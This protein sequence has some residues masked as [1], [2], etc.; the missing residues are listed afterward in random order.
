MII[1]A[2]KSFLYLY[3]ILI[4]FSSKTNLASKQN[5]DKLK[6]Q[7]EMQ[8]AETIQ[9]K[10][11]ANKYVQLTKAEQNTVEQMSKK[12]E[13]AEKAL[14]SYKVKLA[15]TERMKDRA[16]A[17]K[18]NMLDLAH[19]TFINNNKFTKMIEQTKEYANKKE[20][21]AIQQL[22]RA[23]EIKS[24]AIKKQL[25][26]EKYYGAIEQIIKNKENEFNEKENLLKE[27][28][29]ITKINLENII[30]NEQNKI[31]QLNKNYKLANQKIKD[32]KLK[33]EILTAKNESYKVKLS[34]E[35][36]QALELKKEIDYFETQ[37]TQTLGEFNPEP[38]I[39]RMDY[40]VDGVVPHLVKT[41][42]LVCKWLNRSLLDNKEYKIGKDL[43]V[44]DL[45]DKLNQSI[46]L[47]DR[48][49]KNL[50]KN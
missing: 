39:T 46:K 14:E 1:K 36:G 18:R 49:I 24:N 37:L 28:F 22:T 6:D 16:T 34:Q 12:A 11:M 29:K 26:A 21:F 7:L 32:L 8:K 40:Y 42:R 33:K 25:A 35:S 5:K 41:I 27:N 19:H 10:L 15:V 48:K 9:A 23:K 45:L 30:A 20:K 44:E 17:D 47:S 43:K 4:I 38:N 50:T 3:T 13:E 2:N 31:E